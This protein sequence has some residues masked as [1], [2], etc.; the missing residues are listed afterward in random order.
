MN[1]VGMFW[2]RNEA[3]ILEETLTDALRHVDTIFIADDGS[4]DNS[5]DII[6]SIAI[7]NPNKVEHIQREPNKN[8]PAQRNALLN[9]IRER[10][11]AEDTWVQV[12]ESDIFILDT[13]VR[14]AIIERSSDDVVVTWTALNGVR[15]PGTWGINDTYPV[16]NHSIREVLPKCH[17][18]EDMHYT[19][20]P[21]PNLRFQGV[22]RPWPQG[23]GE[24]QTSRKGLKYTP[25]NTPLLFHVGY[26]GPTHFYQKWQK[27]TMGDFHS[28]YKSWDLRSVENVE[29]TVSFF[30]GQWN[31]P[32]ET[33]TPSREGW[34][35]R[36]NYGQ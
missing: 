12:I 1:I 36:K 14:K 25:H 21:F 24:Y 28:R 35:N 33:F 8:D 29:K 31:N 17:Y 30:N 34:I 4:T 19:W 11:R 18:M 23:M 32:K 7:N 2:N 3:D 27:T 13:S 15:D 9:K 16:W 6:K 22:W 20:R 26:R 10:Y 5:W